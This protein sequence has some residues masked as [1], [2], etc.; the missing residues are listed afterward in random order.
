M[1]ICEDMRGDLR[2]IKTKHWDSKRFDFTLIGKE[3]K[4]SKNG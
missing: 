1:G 2:E 3:E 4:S